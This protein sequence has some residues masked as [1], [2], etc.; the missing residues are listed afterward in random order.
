MFLKITRIT[1]L[2]ISIA[3]IVMMALMLGA[4]VAR[5]A[6]FVLPHVVYTVTSYPVEILQLLLFYYLASVL[7]FFN[8]KRSIVISF[9]TFLCVIAITD[10]ALATLTSSAAFVVMA[11]LGS[12]VFIVMIFMVVASFKIRSATIKFPFVLLSIC[13]LSIG[14]LKVI[15][16]VLLPYIIDNFGGYGSIYPARIILNYINPFVIIVPVSVLILATW[17]NRHLAKEVVPA[18]S[19]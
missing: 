7:I 13:L 15:V 17:I 18:E 11:V 9:L 8:E 6:R 5:I 10:I 4:D 19:W 2:L 12:L 1:N 16:A 3:A 14:L